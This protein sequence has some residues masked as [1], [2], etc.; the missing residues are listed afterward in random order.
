MR[1]TT[2]LAVL[3]T[4]L[5]A[6]PALAAQTAVPAEPGSDRPAGA[7]SGPAPETKGK[8][9]ARTTKTKKAKAP[10]PP[11]KAKRR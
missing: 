9:A 11:R 8:P 7:T 5:A 2:A 10:S 4:L 6:S 3:L 1:T